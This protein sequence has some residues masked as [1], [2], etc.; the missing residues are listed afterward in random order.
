MK[1]W[2][3]MAYANSNKAM[4]KRCDN[5]NCAN[6]DDQYW[7]GE[8]CLLLKNFRKCEIYLKYKKWRDT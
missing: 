8:S 5:R 4:I 2:K 1:P 3:R 7:T 6:Y